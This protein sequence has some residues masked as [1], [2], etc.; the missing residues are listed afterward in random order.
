MNFAKI[1]FKNDLNNL[2]L[3]TERQLILAFKPKKSTECFKIKEKSKLFQ[4][5]NII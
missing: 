1:G 4:F 3:L 5:I 2:G